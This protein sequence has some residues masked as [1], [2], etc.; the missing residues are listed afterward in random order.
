VTDTASTGV[1]LWAPLGCEVLICKEGRPRRDALAGLHD[2]N[3]PNRPTLGR[4]SYQSGRLRLKSKTGD[5]CPVR[6]CFTT[7]FTHV[8]SGTRLFNFLSKLETCL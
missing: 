7:T 2:H 3:R 6:G 4:L 5:T 1:P 8:R